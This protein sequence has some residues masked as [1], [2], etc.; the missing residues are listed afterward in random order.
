MAKIE[1][2]SETSETIS[3]SLYYGSLVDLEFSLIADLYNYQHAL[4]DKA[5]FIPRIVTFECLECPKEIKEQHCIS[6]GAFCFTPP[7]QERAN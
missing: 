1:N 7:S 4:K 6:N 3:Y 2:S 5:W